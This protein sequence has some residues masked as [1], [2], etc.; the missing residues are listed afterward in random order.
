MLFVSLQSLL[1]RLLT[2]TNLN[3]PFVCTALQLEEAH[4]ASLNQLSP[5]VAAIRRLYEER[6]AALEKEL[7]EYLGEAVSSEFFPFVSV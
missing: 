7:H 2:L 6:I 3:F 1:D 4:H 5:E